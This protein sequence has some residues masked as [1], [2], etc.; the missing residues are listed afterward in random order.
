MSS[1]IVGYAK[2]RGV[3]AVIL[4][5]DKIAHGVLLKNSPAYPEV[6]GLFGDKILDADGEINRKKIAE[7]VFSNKEMLAKH[8]AITHKY[9]AKLMTDRLNELKKE[10]EIVVMDVPLLIEAN[11]HRECDYVWL[12]SSEYDTKVTRIISRDNLSY[13]QAK[14]RISSQNTQAALSAYAD[15]ILENNGNIRELL[16]LVTDELHRIL[17]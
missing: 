3:T 13:E 2:E 1:L 17:N 7:I 9:I 8:T 11:L 15:F 10:Y 14:A 5:A 4:D 6:V 16:V 12:L